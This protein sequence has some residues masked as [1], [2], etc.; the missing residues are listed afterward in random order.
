MTHDYEM[1]L[2]S[3]NQYQEADLILPDGGR[4]HYIRIS[5]GTGFVDAEFESTNSPTRY[6]KSRIKFNGNGWDLKLLDGTVYVF[7]DVRPMQS[8]RDRFGNTVTLTRTPAQTG[9]ITRIDGPNGRY[10][11]LEYDAANH[12]TKATDNTGRAVLY[13][14]DLLG[15]MT[16]VTYPDGSTNLYGWATCPAGPITNVCTQLLTLTDARGKVSLTNEY[17]GGRVTKQTYVDGSTDLFAYTVDATNNIA[18]V[19]TTNR[20]GNVRRIVFNSSGYVTSSTSALGAPEQQTYLFSRAATGQFIAD[21][22]DPLG[23]I[24][25]SVYDTLGNVTSRTFPYGTPQA[26]TASYTYEPLFQQIKTVIDA[27]GH[28]TTFNYDATGVLIGLQDANNNTVVITNDTAGR[29]LTITDPLSHTTTFEYDGADLVKITD[30]LGRVVQR[31]TDGA[32]RVVGMVD[33]LGNMTRLDYDVFDRLLKRTDALGNV[34]ESTYDPNGNRLTFKDPRGNLTQYAYDDLNRMISRTNPLLKINSFTYDLGGKLLRV[35]DRKGQV[36]GFLYD[37]LN[38]TLQVGYGGTVG[39]P[40]IYE[41]T[42][43]Y[44]YDAGNR[45]L[46]L[47]DSAN[48]TITRAYDSFDRKISE[49]TAQ[50]TVTYTYNNASRRATLQAPGQAQVVYAYDNA[51]RLT[52]IT[53]GTQS[54]G[55]GYDNANRRTSLTLPNGINLTYD[56]DNAN[57]LTG[58]TYKKGAVTLGDLSYGYDLAGRRTSH[59]GSFARTGLPLAQTANTH[60]A[61]NRLTLQDATA[62]SYDDNGNLL[63]D[64]INS[65]T[66]NSRRQLT[67]VA[68]PVAASFQYDAVGRRKQK[69]VAGTTS[70]YLYDGLNIV[71]EQ[72]SGGSVIADHLTSLGIDEVFTRTEGGATKTLL[73]D[74]L[75]STIAMADGTGIVTSWTYDPYGKATYTG[76]A[77][78]NPFLYTGRELDGTGLYYYRARYYHPTLNRFIAEDPI[79]FAGGSNVYAYVGGNPISLV[80][81]LGLASSCG[82][83]IAQCAFYLMCLINGTSP[84]PTVSQPPPPIPIIGIGGKK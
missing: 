3:A 79:G 81:P 34:V 20:R 69:T 78:S 84:P 59:G 21:T 18:Q 27:L 14:Y 25:H 15:R 57:Q 31:L 67:A 40:T 42:I 73:R 71:Q 10:I 1:F 70:T 80:D 56:Y 37:A 44:G 60:D 36:T 66:W 58:I 12:V 4:V 43:S 7:G 61:N 8:M 33:P 19:D 74:A 26:L 76:V 17:T 50:G 22:T 45:L 35:T 54:V 32:G 30:A 24:N 63:N 23:R 46:T 16:K 55:I 72:A 29:P 38:R 64:G 77:Q 49:T 48:G 11:V 5:S 9:N 52:G 39:N 75:G 13:E 2:W 62:L 53:Q 6:F 82:Q 65:Y 68:G 41:S 47:T 83:K 51:K 28:V